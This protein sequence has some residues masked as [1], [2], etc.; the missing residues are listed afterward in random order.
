M[1]P[2]LHAKLFALLVYCS[3]LAMCSLDKD[4]STVARR[5]LGAGGVSFRP[6]PLPAELIVRLKS[7]LFR[8]PSRSS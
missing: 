1:Q 3:M 2:M 6:M 5:V 8:V 7:H 4:L